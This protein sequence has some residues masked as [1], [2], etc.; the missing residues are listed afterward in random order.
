MEIYINFKL[1]RFP[2]VISINF[3]LTHFPLG[4]SINLFFQNPIFQTNPVSIGDLYKYLVPQYMFFIIFWYTG[5]IPELFIS[6]YAQE[7]A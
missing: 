6:K 7:V 2:L 5:I 1:T 4:I 3:K